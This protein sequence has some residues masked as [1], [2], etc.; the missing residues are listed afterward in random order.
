MIILNYLTM[1]DVKII[2][3]G[4]HSAIV[5]ISVICL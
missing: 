5:D 2:T 4:T 1:K 3:K